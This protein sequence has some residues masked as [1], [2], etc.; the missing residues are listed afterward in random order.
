[1]LRLMRDEDIPDLRRLWEKVFGDGDEYLD[2]FFRDLYQTGSGV[3]INEN[4]DLAAMGFLINIGSYNDSDC[5]VTYAVACDPNYR[6]RGF[7][8]EISRKLYDMSG[9]GG[10]ICPAEPSLF[11]FYRDRTEYKTEFYVTGL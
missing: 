6:G 1:M 2:L 3:V 9:E 7:G 4:D 8:G 5:L 11:D 10:V